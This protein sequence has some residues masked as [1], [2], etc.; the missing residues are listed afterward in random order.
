MWEDFS[1]FY[2]L[3][4]NIII[5]EHALITFPNLLYFLDFLVV[6]KKEKGYH[7]LGQN[8]HHQVLGAWD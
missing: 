5:L 6:Y 3:Y 7:W 1:K 4:F 8:A 2:S